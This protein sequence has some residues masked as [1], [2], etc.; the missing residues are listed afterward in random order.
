[1]ILWT[2]VSSGKA[3]WASLARASQCSA[4][5]WADSANPE[6]ALAARAVERATTNSS[7][8]AVVE[9][10][11]GMGEGSV[12]PVILSGAYPA[13]RRPALV[14]VRRRLAGSML[15]ELGGRVR[16]V[17]DLESMARMSA[18]HKAHLRMFA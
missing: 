13:V 3:S 9:A 12:P 4:M 18:N 1:M 17:A 16:H 7:G 15:Q 2:L 11:V 5:A 8:A 6:A 14:S 10:S